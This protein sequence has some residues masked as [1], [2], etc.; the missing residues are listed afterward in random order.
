M[1]VTKSFPDNVVIAGN[2][3]RIIKTIE[4]GET[5]EEIAKDVAPATKSTT[6][7]VAAID[8]QR[9]TIDAINEN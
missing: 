6:E 9:E 2:P 3:A 5:I 4:S 8:H 1:S 7:V